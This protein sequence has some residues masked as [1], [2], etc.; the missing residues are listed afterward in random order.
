M[1][2]GGG[3]VMVGVLVRNLFRVCVLVVDQSGGFWYYHRQLTN[4][5]IGCCI[6]VVWDVYRITLVVRGLTSTIQL[7]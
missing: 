2:G 5:T 6:G 3:G 1:L 7:G 4:Y